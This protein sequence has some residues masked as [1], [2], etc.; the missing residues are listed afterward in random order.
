MF[1]PVRQLQYSFF[2]PRSLRA[3]RLHVSLDQ[4]S[5]FPGNTVAVHEIFSRCAELRLH[6]AVFQPGRLLLAGF[7]DVL[8]DTTAVRY[9]CEPLLFELNLECGAFTLAR[10]T[11]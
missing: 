4:R 3:D 2:F 5:I 9:A 10:R 6:V 8:R 1:L 7:T 11:G